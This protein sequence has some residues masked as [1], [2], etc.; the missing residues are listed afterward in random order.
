M[1]VDEGLRQAEHPGIVFKDGPSGRRAAL[2]LGPDIWEVIRVLA[3]VDERGD[4]AVTAAAELMYLEAGRVRL[5]LRYYAAFRAEIDQEIAEAE[6]AS[7][8]AERAWRSEQH[9]LA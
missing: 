1:S 9:L 8:D 7:L 3:E 2:A 4:A 5:A 6:A